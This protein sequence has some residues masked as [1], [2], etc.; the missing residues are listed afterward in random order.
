MDDEDNSHILYMIV[1][2][3]IDDENYHDVFPFLNLRKDINQLIEQKVLANDKLY[4]KGIISSLPMR[5]LKDLVVN[6]TNDIV[7]AIDKCQWFKVNS[8][9]KAKIQS[10]IYDFL[11]DAIEEHDVTFYKGVGFKVLDGSNLILNSTSSNFIAEKLLKIIDKIITLDC[12]TI[13]WK[14]NYKAIHSK[15]VYNLL[16]NV[17]KYVTLVKTNS[18]NSTSFGR[19]NYYSNR[20]QQSGF[21]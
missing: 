21:I 13:E 4:Q 15:N 11:L 12:I 16:N 10:V 17:S 8:K 14:S 20:Y 3:L 2:L 9:E 5:R 6:L 1:A 7:T 18:N 19:Y